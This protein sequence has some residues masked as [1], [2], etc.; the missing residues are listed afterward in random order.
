MVPLVILM[1]LP[2]VT[3]WPRI[4]YPLTSVCKELDRDVRGQIPTY[5]CPLGH[6]KAPST[7]WDPWSPTAG[8]QEETPI[9]VCIRHCGATA[10]RG[11]IKTCT[12]RGSVPE[13]G[14]G[15]SSCWNRRLGAQVS[16]QQSVSNAA[17]SAAGLGGMSK[18]SDLTPDFA[19]ML[20]RLGSL[21]LLPTFKRSLLSCASRHLP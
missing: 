21:F 13:W 9:K 20:W 2:T 1:R 14:W 11:V 10:T 3:N 8:R 6:C 12:E 4:V 19:R 7:L 5:P 18:M 16:L 17:A 15:G